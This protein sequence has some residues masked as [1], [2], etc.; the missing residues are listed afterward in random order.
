MPTL[1]DHKKLRKEIEKQ[2]LKQEPLAELLNISVRH[3]RNMC[4]K[5][6]NVSISLLHRI[7]EVLHVPMNDLL[8]TEEEQE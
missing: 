3:L 7:S 4:T 1:L 6:I 8:I 2:K 5:N